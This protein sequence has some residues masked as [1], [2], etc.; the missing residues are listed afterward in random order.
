[1]AGGISVGTRVIRCREVQVNLDI[2][3]G[4]GIQGDQKGQ[5][6]LGILRD[7]ADP[8]IR[9]ELEDLDIRVDLAV[10]EWEVLRGRGS[11]RE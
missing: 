8:G 9:A 5:G 3:A 1:M 2:Q 10:R 6:G 4:K 11:L 7:Q